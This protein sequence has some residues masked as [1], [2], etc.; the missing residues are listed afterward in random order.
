[1]DSRLRNIADPNRE[2]Y[3]GI[4]C[5][6]SAA[7]NKITPGNI[8]AYL[9]IATAIYHLVVKRPDIKVEVNDILIKQYY[10]IIIVEP[11]PNPLPDTPPD[12]IK[13]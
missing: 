9:A 13:E 8:A 12:P 1:M 5:C 6:E 10:Q 2:N 7:F 4:L 11:V 3:A